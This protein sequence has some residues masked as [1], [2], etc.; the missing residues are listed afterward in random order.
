MKFRK[1]KTDYNDTFKKL[2][3]SKLFSTMTSKLKE[4]IKIFSNKYLLFLYLNGINWTKL[5]VIDLT[6]NILPVIPVS[7]TDCGH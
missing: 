7:T 6:G 5:F 2:L 1:R 4:S 3:S